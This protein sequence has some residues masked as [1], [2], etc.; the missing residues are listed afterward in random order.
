M[1]TEEKK[2][3]LEELNRMIEQFADEHD[4]EVF[5]VT[6]VTEVGEEKTD[7]AVGEVLI[8]KAKN[9]IPSIM[10]C[11]RFNPMIGTIL[12]TSVNR[13]AEAEYKEFNV[14]KG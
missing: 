5:A 6:S 8:G 3:A 2:K 14:I 12:T 10:G 9:L 11:I 13:A 4:I 1:I 7:Q